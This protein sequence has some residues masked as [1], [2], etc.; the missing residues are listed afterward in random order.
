MNADRM[1]ESMPYRTRHHVPKPAC[2]PFAHICAIATGLLDP[3][4]LLTD[5]RA[6]APL[7]GF[8]RG[9]CRELR[10]LS[11]FR[12]NGSRSRSSRWS[13]RT[14]AP[15]NRS[16][17]GP[18]AL[19]SRRASLRRL[20][21]APQESAYGHSR[22]N[23]GARGGV[24]ASRRAG[25]SWLPPEPAR[26]HGGPNSCTGLPPG[27]QAG[28]AAGKACLRH[29]SPHPRPGAP[30]ADADA[31][32]PFVCGAGSPGAF[33]SEPSRSSFA[34]ALTR[35]SQLPCVSAGLVIPP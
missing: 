14:N 4:P 20:D 17:S 29:S 9:C 30:G 3:Q 35:A 7:P 31:A 22:P 21:H 26:R 5:L 15:A 27:R 25:S 34:R 24:C 19:M 11:G 8:P 12:T 2:F 6:R 1:F 13:I 33:L 16:S 32:R 18:G 23:D 28:R 10:L